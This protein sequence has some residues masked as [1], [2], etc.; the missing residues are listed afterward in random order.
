MELLAGGIVVAGVGMTGQSRIMQD[1]LSASDGHIIPSL[2]GSTITFL[3]RC[4]TPEPQVLVH[5]V[6]PDQIDTSQST[7]TGTGGGVGTAGHS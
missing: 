4:S 6:H 3:E 7:A 5:F 1:L 2:A